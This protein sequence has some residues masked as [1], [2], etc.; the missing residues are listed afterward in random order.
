MLPDRRL[1]FIAALSLFAAPRAF[2]QTGASDASVLLRLINDIRRQ[3]GAPPVSLSDRAMRAAQ[4]QANAMAAG[5]SVSHDAGG[6]FDARM[7]ANGIRGFAAENVA[8]GHNDIAAAFADWQ[9]S[10]LHNG[11]MLNPRARKIGLG[12]ARGSNGRNYWALVLT[13][14]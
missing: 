5:N 4:Q 8:G 7:N 14:N 10:S 1:A 9:S 11:N 12:R 3:N 6:G 2:A 13:A